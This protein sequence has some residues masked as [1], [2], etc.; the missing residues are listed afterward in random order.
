[1]IPFIK[2]KYFLLTFFMAD[3]S[4]IIQRIQEVIIEEIFSSFL[5]VWSWSKKKFDESN[6]GFPLQIQDYSYKN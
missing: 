6:S 4:T 5:I 1:M 2:S 3:S